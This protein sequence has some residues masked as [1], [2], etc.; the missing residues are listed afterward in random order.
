MVTLNF[1][2]M[3]VSLKG[4]LSFLCLCVSCLL[5]SD[6]ACIGRIFIFFLLF[7]SHARFMTLLQF[8]TMGDWN[9]ALLSFCQ[10]HLSLSVSGPDSLWQYGEGHNTKSH[11]DF[12]SISLCHL[13][14]NMALLPCKGTYWVSVWGTYCLSISQSRRLSS[15][16]CLEKQQ[17][18]SWSGAIAK[19]VLATKWEI[20]EFCISYLEHFH[21]LTWHT[22]HDPQK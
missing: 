20:Y 9:V 22:T 7:D 16:I 11:T 8:T 14:T 21:I 17:N 19:H 3:W 2:E 4:Y 15:L 5:H 18:A 10:T 12:H 6:Y 13:L 1:P